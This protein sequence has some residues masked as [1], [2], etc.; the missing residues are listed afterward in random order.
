MSFKHLCASF[1]PSL[2]NSCSILYSVKPHL[3]KRKYKYIYIKKLER[4]RVKC[5]EQLALMSD[6]CS[7]RRGWGWGGTI[8]TLRKKNHLLNGNEV[9]LKSYLATKSSWLQLMIHLPILTAI[10]WICENVLWFIVLQ[11]NTNIQDSALGGLGF[12]V[13]IINSPCSVG[14]TSLRGKP[15]REENPLL[16][17]QG[18]CGS[19]RCFPKRTWAFETELLNFLTLETFPRSTCEKT[20]SN[21]NP[22]A[23]VQSCKQPAEFI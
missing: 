23:R 18:S 20:A 6:F 12:S 14:S 4:H 10:G 9:F 3:S 7:V 5:W 21:W 19:W 11:T 22:S 2:K 15:E 1:L 17:G 13:L 8:F 16:S